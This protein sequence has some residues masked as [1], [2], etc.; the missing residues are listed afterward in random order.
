LKPIITGTLPIYEVIPH[1]I[2]SL[3]KSNRLVLQAPPGA[4]K[5]TV[6]PLE[7]LNQSWLDN[8]KII[9]LEPRRLA[10]IAS[11]RRMAQLLGEQVGETV[12][13]RVRLDSKV[14]KDTRIEVITEGILIRM[15]LDDPELTGVGAILFDEFH[16]RSVLADLGLALAVD[17]QE[18]LREDLRILLMS[19]TLDGEQMGEQF[20]APVVSSEGRMF[21]VE[22][23]WEP[24][25]D[26]EWLVDHC[27]RIIKKELSQSEG[28]ILTFLPGMG[29]IK[30]LAEKLHNG[31]L[32]DD[33]VIAPLYGTLNRTEQDRAILPSPQGKRKVVLAT[34]IAETSLTIDG[35]TIVI[36]SGLHREPRFNSGSGMT[37]LVTT[38]ISQA[39]AKQRTG[40]AGRTAPGRSIRLWT[41]QSHGSRIAFQ[42]PEIITAELSSTLLELALW[43]VTEPTSLFWFNQPP[44]SSIETAKTLLH[45][46]GA[47]DNSGRITEQ[48]KAIASIG[49]HPRLAKIVVEGARGRESQLACDLAALLSERDILR[50]RDHFKQADITLRLEQINRSRMGARL[51]VAGFHVDH[52]TVKRIVQLSNSL[53]SRVKETLL[54]QTLATQT[55]PNP[56]RGLTESPPA[57]DLGGEVSNST[58]SIGA[59]LALGFP[60]RVGRI[61]EQG[62]GRYLLSGGSGV[63][64]GEGDPLANAELI[65][66]AECAAKERDATVFLAAEICGAEVEELFELEMQPISE[67]FWDAREKRVVAREVI[68]LGSIIFSERRTTTLAPEQIC[69]AVIEGIREMGISSLPW[70]KSSLAL[71]DRLRFLHL[72]FPDNWLGFSEEEL[73][74]TLEEWLAPFLTGISKASQFGN[75]NLLS[76]LKSQF[77]WN[78]QQEID[79]LAPERIKVPEGS[80]MRIDYSEN[81]PVLAVK[82][83]MMFG[84]TETPSVGGGTVP[85]LIH[86]LSPA[87]RPVQI[88][89]DLVGFWDGSYSEVKKEMKGRYPKHPWPDNPRDAVATARTKRAELRRK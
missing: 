72:H 41:E 18:G 35:V 48:G 45:R 53:M 22:I 28:S 50:S 32:P 63:H 8:Q 25:R 81:P 51:G 19:A 85:V 84:A 20:G 6:V 83:Q 1:I 47:L 33:V 57:G 73:L 88:T 70:N 56:H 43:G 36:D 77:D 16:E 65:V 54:T 23:N 17:V 61:R 5:T 59:L 21:P 74:A 60:E 80:N 30:R 2:T 82:L 75:I 26:R 12:G 44:H 79:R 4:G 34:N 58:L 55:P 40:R 31:S 71:L 27:Y 89:Q 13:Y 52:G 66:V 67:L 39:S 38:P 14:S 24:A 78:K 69:T 86:L 76:A 15:I 87:G 68:R 49:V 62:S 3:S 9:I 10:T 29:E 37:Q 11:A 46:L 7:L 64:F 42:K